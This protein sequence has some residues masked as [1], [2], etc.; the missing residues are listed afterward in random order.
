MS[1]ELIDV[2]RAHIKKVMDAMDLPH[3]LQGNLRGVYIGISAIFYAAKSAGCAETLLPKAAFLERLNARLK[4]LLA[5]P[6]KP[7]DKN[8]ELVY[9]HREFANIVLVRDLISRVLADTAWIVCKRN[10]KAQPASLETN[11]IASSSGAAFDGQQEPLPTYV[12]TWSLG[13]Y[14]SQAA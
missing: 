3:K 6:P 5:H 13:F 11:A 4:D 8:G 7:V 2:W 9:D 10:W 1:D 14:L 12:A